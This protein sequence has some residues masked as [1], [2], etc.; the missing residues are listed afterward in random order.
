MENY[1]KALLL[2][3]KAGC[4]KLEASVLEN[5][6]ATQ[7]KFDRVDLAG[8]YRYFIFRRNIKR[9][10]QEFNGNFEKIGGNL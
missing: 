2:A 7:L 10:H 3:K 6:K 4:L 5:M 9:Y 1:E 8:T